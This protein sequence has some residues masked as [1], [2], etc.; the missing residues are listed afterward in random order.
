MKM[1]FSAFQV[2]FFVFMALFLIGG[3]CIILTQTFGIVIGS[4][5]V[6]SGV[7]HWLAPVT[8]SCATLC[9]VCAFVLTYR[10]KPQ[11]TKH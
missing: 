2:L 11:G 10:P 5:D 8:Y 3:V 1:V 4:G 7:E 6:V 9:A